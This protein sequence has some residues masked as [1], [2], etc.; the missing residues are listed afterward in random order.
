MLNRLCVSVASTI[1]ALAVTTADADWPNFRG[2]NHDGISSEKGLK[3]SWTGSIPLK[4]ERT[5]GSA[6][7]SFACVGDHVYT[8]GTS[9]KQQVLYCLNA[10]TGA[11]VWQKPFDKEFRDPQGGDGTRATPTVDGGRVY[12]LGGHGLLLCADAATGKEIWSK[13]FAYEPQWGYS[14]SILIEG[15]LAIASAGKDAGALVAFDKKTGKEIWKCGDD[16]AGYGTPYPFTFNGRRYV[17]GFTGKTAIIA[18][19]RTG[20]LVWRIPWKTD[21]DVNAASP[22]FHNGYLFLSSGYRTGSAL[23]KLGAGGDK[24]SSQTVWK[25]NVL[26]NKF[27]SCILHK[28]KLYSSD[29]K[30]LVCVDFMTGKEIWRQARLDDRLARF[31][32]L[33]LAQDH[34]LLLTQEGK[35]KI[36]RASPEGFRPTTSADILNGRCWTVPVLHRGRLYARNLDRVVCLDLRE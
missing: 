26:M 20:K 12:V 31:G 21:Y 32:T 18:E 14:G 17:V 9:D 35:L 25:S 4:W 5:I 24:L 23:L 10:E 2:P 29:Q 22:I 8:C 34:L 6:F 19:V 15:D 27:Q 13:R 30:A 36:A 7:S 3:T 16:P 1:V 11:V 28:G 33:V